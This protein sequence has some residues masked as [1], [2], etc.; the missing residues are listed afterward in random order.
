MDHQ[1]EYLVV[2]YDDQ[3]QKVKLS[4]HQADILDALAMDEA[5]QKQGGCVPDLQRVARYAVTRVHG[6]VAEKSQG[7]RTAPDV[8]SRIRPIY[9]RSYA[10]KTLGHRLQGSLGRGA[11]HEVEV[12]A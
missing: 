9:A 11:E 7:W 8:P 6:R 10:W 3:E 4:L 1:I 2:A 12:S 5:L